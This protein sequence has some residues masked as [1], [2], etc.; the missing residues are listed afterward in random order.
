MHTKKQ[1]LI[2][3]GEY[4][5]NCKTQNG[6]IFFTLSIIYTQITMKYL[7]KKDRVSVKVRVG[8]CEVV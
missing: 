2:F 4:G 7:F 3:L 6:N 5:V 1:F 8:V